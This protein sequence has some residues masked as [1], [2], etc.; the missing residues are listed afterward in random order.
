[1]NINVSFHNV[2]HSDS[3]ESFIRSK[4]ES[5]SKFLHGSDHLR[6]VVE[7]SGNV[8]EP[9]LDLILDGKNQLVK[10]AADDAFKAVADVIAKSQRLLRDRHEKKSKLH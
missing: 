8:F 6:W 2:D 1:M 4:S 9:H 7:V 3:L 5:L 10:S